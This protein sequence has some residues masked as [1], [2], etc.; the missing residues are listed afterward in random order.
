M[1]Q[2]PPM[3]EWSNCVAICLSRL[4]PSVGILIFGGFLFVFLLNLAGNSSGKGSTD[5][6]G[7]RSFLSQSELRP[8]ILENTVL[9]FGLKKKR[10]QRESSDKLGFPTPF[11][12]LPHRRTHCQGPKCTKKVCNLVLLS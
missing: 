9:T 11:L 7:P 3:R 12:N 1:P 6:W 2:L 8:E 4:Y 5:S 10:E